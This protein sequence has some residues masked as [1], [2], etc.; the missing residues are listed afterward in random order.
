MFRA[1]VVLVLAG[2]VCLPGHSQAIDN[3]HVVLDFANATPGIYY[4]EVTVLANGNITFAP[5]KKII[6]IGGTPTPPVTPGPGP[7]PPLPIPPVITPPPAPTPM[8]EPDPIPMDQ[9]E[10]TVQ[11]LTQ[12][13]IDK[14]GA[15]TTAVSL[16]R[17]YKIVVDAVDVGQIPHDKTY[18]SLK[19]GTDLIFGGDTDEA[20]RWQTWRLSVS[21]L[22]AKAQSQGGLKTKAEIVAMVRKIENGLKNAV[23]TNGVRD[24]RS[25]DTINWDSV[26]KF[27]KKL[28]EDLKLLKGK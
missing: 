22:L 20:A 2:L 27:S 1:A 14:G 8:P 9:I 5:I 25:M 11:A 4:Y 24:P 15:V 23:N 21:A 3:H 28:M 6:S 13:A 26:L 17:V 12:N 16:Q 10:L 18:E 19:V 7:A